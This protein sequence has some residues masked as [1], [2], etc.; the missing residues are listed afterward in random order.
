MQRALLLTQYCRA[1]LISDNIF[2]DWLELFQEL[3][4]RE[5]KKALPRS[6]PDAHESYSHLRQ[7]FGGHGPPLHSWFVVSEQVE[8]CGQDGV[9]VEKRGD[10]NAI[11]FEG[12][13][14]I[15]AFHSSEDGCIALG[16]DDQ[17]SP[18]SFC[19]ETSESIM[20]WRGITSFG[21]TSLQRA[22]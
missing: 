16:Q 10:G 4:M 2:I 18:V 6:T 22:S 20:D 5:V 14:R 12:A 9:G 19:C 1:F 11:L 21:K 17:G 13:Y 15:Y 8:T 3:G 7:E